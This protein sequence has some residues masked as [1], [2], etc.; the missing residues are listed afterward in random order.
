MHDLSRKLTLF[1]HIF[2]EEI[3]DCTLLCIS[4]MSQYFNGHYDVVTFI[5]LII[6][7]NDENVYLKSI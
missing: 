1:K 7:I 5:F 4:E 6:L 3:D 2:P